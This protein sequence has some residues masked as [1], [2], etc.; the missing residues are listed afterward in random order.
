MNISNFD[1]NLLRVLDALLRER[2]VSRAAERLSLSQPAVSNALARL[3]EL[4]DDPLLVRVGREMQPT[5]RAKA[6]ESPI[7]QALQQIHTSLTA[8]D[9]FDPATSTAKFTLALTDYAEL[10][11]MP[12]LLHRLGQ[13]APGMQIAIRDLTPTLP[14]EAMDKGEIDLALGRFLE[15]PQRFES[16]LWAT[17][18]LQVVAHPKHPLFACPLTLERF[19]AL[20]HLWVHGG[21]TRGMV[22]QWLEGQGLK[23]RIVY[24]TPNYLQAAHVV[25][26]SDLAVVLPTRLAEYFAKL[27]PLALTPLPFALEPF[28]LHIVTHHQ[29]SRDTALQW[30][31][32]QIIAVGEMH[33]ADRG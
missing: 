33:T 30:L 12:G 16:R 18:T 23:R 21:Q 22:D 11:C 9:T 27:L 10:A 6:L 4:L 26:H 29:R 32:A 17:E 19:L 20:R 24:T 14:A 2:N 15:L 13:R 5:A 1:L 8:G 7:R 3:R 25:A 28:H 31:I